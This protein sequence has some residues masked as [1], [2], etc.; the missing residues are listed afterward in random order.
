MREEVLY[1]EALTLGL[2]RDDTIVRR[3]LRQKM[4]FV[5][6]EAA[7][8][9]QPTDNELAD[10]LAAHPDAF[11]VE[12]RVTFAQVYLDPRR[13]A[14]TFAADAARLLGELNRAGARAS[15]KL[16]DGLLLLEPRYENAS[17]TDVARLFGDA[18]GEA[19]FQQPRGRWVGPIES[20]YG[21][22]LVRVETIVPGGVATL[23]DVRPLVERE[24]GKRQAQGTE[25]SV[26]CAASQQ[27]QGDDQDARVRSQRR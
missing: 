11:R 22:H 27:I 18:F 15:A 9:A 14:K 21:A 17:R 19:L 13:R 8:L 2:D 6:D 1:R 20:G 3:R 5:S 25:R 12:P 7:A 16:G 4:E 10:Y 24:W 23:G 26:L